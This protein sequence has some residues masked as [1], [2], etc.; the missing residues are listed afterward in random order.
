MVLSELI[1]Y[2]I[3]IN[4]VGVPTVKSRLFEVINILDTLPNS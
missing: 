3:G 1:S 4:P 2:N